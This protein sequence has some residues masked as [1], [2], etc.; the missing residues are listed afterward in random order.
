LAFE[1]ARPDYGLA[2]AISTIIF[3]LVAIFSYIGFKR[4]ATLEEIN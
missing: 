2:A 3:F 4:T 1:A